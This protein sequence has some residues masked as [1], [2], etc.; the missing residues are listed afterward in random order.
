M[1]LRLEMGPTSQVGR[2][3]RDDVTEDLIMEFVVVYVGLYRYKVRA[4]FPQRFAYKTNDEVDLMSIIDLRA[5]AKECHDLAYDVISH[6]TTS[7]GEVCGY[8]HTIYTCF[9]YFEYN[10]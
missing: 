3:T 4:T 2:A 10:F 6:D 5:C 8:I 1:T 7:R 9:I